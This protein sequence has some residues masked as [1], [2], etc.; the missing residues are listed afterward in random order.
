MISIIAATDKAGAI[1]KNGSI[2]WDMPE[3]RRRFRELTV[4]NVVV[5]GRRTYEDIGHPLPERMN[6]I[7]SS[8]IEVADDNCVTMHSLKDVLKRF[9][10]R[11][12]FICGGANVY[13]E[14]LPYA[15]RIYLTVIDKVYHGDV[16]FPEIS[17]SQFLNVYREKFG[18]EPAFSFLTYIRK[19]RRDSDVLE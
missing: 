7:L 3:D 19:K 5:M 14:A 11:D 16:F 1:G 15:D 4:N 18:S 13:S 2:P 9:A 8:T 10:D 6:V 12:I 17:E